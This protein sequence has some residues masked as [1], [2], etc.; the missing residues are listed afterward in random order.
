M[1]KARI[2][3]LV[4]PTLLFTLVAGCRHGH[5]EKQGHSHTQ[6]AH[7]HEKD[8]KAHTGSSHGQDQETVSV[9]RYSLRTE[10]F[11]EYP[12]LVARTSTSFLVHATILGKTF[13]PVRVG[14]LK[15][16][17]LRKGKTIHE[18]VADRPKRTGIFKPSGT[19]PAA[20]DYRCTSTTTLR[21][22]IGS[23]FSVTSNRT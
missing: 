22:R 8:H 13:V 6:P 16:L 12:P 9:T 14:R 23:G 17:F 1:E 20:G 7:G 5:D 3:T 15:L 19:V 4:F 2:P 10:I 18:L 11:M 21:A